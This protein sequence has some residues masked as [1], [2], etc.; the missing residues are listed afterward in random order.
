MLPRGW[1]LVVSVIQVEKY[2]FLS[3]SS[4][5]VLIGCGCEQMCLSAWEGVGEGVRACMSVCECM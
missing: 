1:R 4:Q 2:D 3:T 5:L